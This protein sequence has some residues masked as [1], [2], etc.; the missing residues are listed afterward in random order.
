M[1]RKLKI[2]INKLL[3]KK[4]NEYVFYN[5]IIILIYKNKRLNIIFQYKI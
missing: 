2:A 1:N 5:N 3:I 4:W